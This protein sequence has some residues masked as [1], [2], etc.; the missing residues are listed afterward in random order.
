MAVHDRLKRLGDVGNGVHVVDL[1]GGND[2][3]K[4]GPIF[5]P[6]LMTA[7]ERVFFW[8]NRSAGSLFD[9]IGVELETPVI[10][11]ARQ[12]PPM[13]ER[14]ADVLSERRAARDHRQLFL[15]PRL[16]R[17]DEGQRVFLAAAS[18]MSGDEPHT[19]ASMA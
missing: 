19:M 15:E 12:S 13:I 18:L 10:E 6:D 9:R 17:L 3:R 2:R 8:S 7:E 5:G 4:Q 11:E 14:A 16:Q 1:A